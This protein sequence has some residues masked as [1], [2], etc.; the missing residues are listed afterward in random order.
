MN[1]TFCNYM[2]LFCCTCINVVP[3]CITDIDWRYNRYQIFIFTELCLAD[4]PCP[5]APQRFVRNGSSTDSSSI[6]T[7]S[8]IARRSVSKCVAIAPESATPVGC[9]TLTRLDG[10]ESCSHHFHSW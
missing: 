9:A 6:L 10:Q 8:L 1:V 2:H 5:D 3:A 7:I 4:A